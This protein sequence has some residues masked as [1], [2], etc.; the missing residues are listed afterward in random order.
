MLEAE[1]HRL[2]ENVDR[3][4]SID[5]PIGERTRL[6]WRISDRLAVVLD[7]LQKAAHLSSLLTGDSGCGT[8][9]RSRTRSAKPST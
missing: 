5:T 3:F 9:P 4:L 7:D 2:R 1:L 8:V 6:A